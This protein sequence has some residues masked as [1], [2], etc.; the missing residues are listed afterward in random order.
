MIP[1]AR[2]HLAGAL[3]RLSGACIALARRVAPG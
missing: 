1:L 3:L 2:L